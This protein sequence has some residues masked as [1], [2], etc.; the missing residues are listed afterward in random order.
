MPQS[1]PGLGLDLAL[2]EHRMGPGNSPS[3][4][5]AAVRRA[6]QPD[7]GT[8]SP[9]CWPRWVFTKTRVLKCG[10]RKGPAQLTHVTGGETE[11]R[12]PQRHF[13]WLH[14]PLIS[15]VQLRLKGPDAKVSFLC[16]SQ[17]LPQQRLHTTTFL[18]GE[19][20]KEESYPE[21]EKEVRAPRGMEAGRWG[22]G[23]NRGNKGLGVRQ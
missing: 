17:C 18:P 13:L 23:Q 5:S 22:K 4:H 14:Q 8:N 11:S 16:S 15:K 7:S 6:S 3:P 9:S 12:R 21:E 20:E 19:E 10:S 2:Q 1:Y